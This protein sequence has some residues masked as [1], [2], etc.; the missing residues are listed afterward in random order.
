MTPKIRRFGGVIL[1]K[2][3]S[4]PFV[5][6]DFI[7]CCNLN[8]TNSITGLTSDNTLFVVLQCRVSAVGQP[9]CRVTTLW[10]CLQNHRRHCTQTTWSFP[11]TTSL[12]QTV[13]TTT[14]TTS[15][16]QTTLFPQT[17]TSLPQTMTTTQT[18]SF[19]RETPFPRTM[20]SSTQTIST[21]LIQVLATPRTTGLTSLPP[22]R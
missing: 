19:P 20:T 22:L 5:C 7:N 4:E 12:P 9:S 17:T 14:Q 8:S 6:F 2:R 21:R 13:T 1:N 3:S 15:G 10:L 16:P 18:I 11:Q